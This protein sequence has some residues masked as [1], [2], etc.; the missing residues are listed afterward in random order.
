MIV[1]RVEDEN[2]YGP[3]NGPNS[4]RGWKLPKNK[5]AQLIEA[6]Y[7]DHNP[8][9]YV[10]VPA[11]N[12]TARGYSEGEN[13]WKF[14]F[15][16]ADQLSRWFGRAVEFLAGAFTVAKYE[17]PDTGVVLGGHQV[18]FDTKKAKLVERRPITKTSDL[19]NLG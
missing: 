9:P 12:L 19:V 16:D 2:A 6:M 5:E 13:R 10:D 7:G 1:Y 14:G 17:V 18:V 11:F 3:Y 4:I 8:P 15:A